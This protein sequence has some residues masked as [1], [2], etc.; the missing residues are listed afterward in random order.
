[1]FTNQ[2]GDTMTIYQY[3]GKYQCYQNEK[4]FIRINVEWYFRKH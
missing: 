3:L 4:Q 2:R 1:M